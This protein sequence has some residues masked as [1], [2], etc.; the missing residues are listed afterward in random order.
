MLQPYPKM[1]ARQSVTP[2][3]WHMKH[4]SFIQHLPDD[5]FVS[6]QLASQ[7]KVRVGRKDVCIRIGGVG[8]QHKKNEHTNEPILLLLMVQTRKLQPPHTPH[9]QYRAKAPQQTRW[10]SMMHHPEF[11]SLKLSKCLKL[12][13]KPLL[14][15]TPVM[16]AGNC[17]FVCL[18]EHGTRTDASE[19]SSRPISSSLSAHVYYQF[20]PTEPGGGGG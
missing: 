4:S 12:Q 11:K 1:N 3:M 19:R 16:D 2:Y 13:R 14:G 8:P 20:V 10:S 17:Q 5:T 15:I 6:V 9:F 18:A 7:T